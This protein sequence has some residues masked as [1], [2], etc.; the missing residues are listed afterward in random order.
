MSVIPIPGSSSETWPLPRLERPALPWRPRWS[1]WLLPAAALLVAAL[2]LLPPIYLVVRTSQS[3]A[4]AL[5][6]LTRAST[7]AALGR[8]TVLMAAVTLASA[9]LAVPL[10]WLTTCSDLPGRR[11]WTVS[12]ALPLALPSFVVAYLFVSILGPRGLVQQL[13]EPLTGWQRLPDLYGFPSAFIVLTL[14]SYPFVF[15]G[16]RAALLRQDPSLAEAARSL[17]LSSRRVFW[18]V[19]LPQ[20]RPAIIAGSLLVSLYVLRDFGAVTLLRYNTFTS[21]IYLQYRSFLD[22]SLAAALALILVGITAAILLAEAR[23]RG[24]AAYA[25]SSAGAPRQPRPVALGWLRWP[26]LALAGL[27]MTLGLLLPAAGLGYWLWRGLDEGRVLATLARPAWNSF[28]VS[29]GAAGLAVMAAVPVAVTSVRRPGRLA[30]FIERL[31]YSGFALPGIVVALAMVFFGITYARSLY[32]TLA[33]LLA[34]YVI[35]F[36]PQAVGALRA[37]MLQVP[38]GL[39]E[40]GR[41]LGANPLAVFGRVTLPLL[42]PGLLAG[43]G[44]VFLTAMKELPAALIV[45]PIGF[46]T[47]ATSVWGSISEAFFAEAAAP[48]LLLILLS[49]IPLAVLSLREK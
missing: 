5:E 47:L 34:A 27:V 33:M 32:Q 12:L 4:A 23:T 49:S 38:P 14:I 48:A 28:G 13:V 17:G 36:L 41:S 21:L 24:R 42:R 2:M 35:L 46:R 1:R 6:I 45:S 10:A 8:T 25:R 18:R 40:A 31:A 3:G 39:E 37:A 30:T 19:T 9:A 11:F 7:L 29:L 15:L 26:A 22:R 20:L 16:V 44:L 43:G